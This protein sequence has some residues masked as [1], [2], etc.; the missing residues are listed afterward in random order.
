MTVKFNEDSPYGTYNLT[1]SIPSGL[2]WLG[3]SNVVS[4][5]NSDMWVSFSQDGQRITGTVHRPA[6]NGT[7]MPVP[8]VES[9]YVRF[10]PAYVTPAENDDITDEPESSENTENSEESTSSSVSKI[11]P[12]VSGNTDMDLEPDPGETA[13]EPKEAQ[14]AQEEDAVEDEI[15][16]PEDLSAGFNHSQPNLPSRQEPEDPNTLVFSYYLS[17][18]LPGSFIT[19]STWLSWEND[20]VKSDRGTISISE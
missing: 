8:R 18:A 19:E 9:A 14:I 15:Y 13:E 11:P 6:P 7:E 3:G 20:T 4:P 17:A 1:D 5:L 10:L 2:R 12:N 16:D